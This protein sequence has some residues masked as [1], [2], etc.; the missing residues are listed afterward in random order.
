MIFTGPNLTNVFDRVLQAAM[1]LSAVA[2]IGSVL[3]VVVTSKLQESAI[4]WAAWK[5]AVL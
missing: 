5:Q 3:M 2:V 4:L 1:S